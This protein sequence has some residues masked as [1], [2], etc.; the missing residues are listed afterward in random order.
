M[1]NAI[2]SFLM[3]CGGALVVLRLCPSEPGGWISKLL[4][5]DVIND[6]I[7]AV[8]VKVISFLGFTSSAYQQF[9]SNLNSL[10]HAFAILLQAVV[11]AFVFWILTRRI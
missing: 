1:R 6:R 8:T 4:F 7:E 11:I 2:R 3:L 9:A 5:D 10:A